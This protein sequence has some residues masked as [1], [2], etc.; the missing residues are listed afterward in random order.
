MP[1]FSPTTV[2]K[3]IL[4][5]GLLNVWLLRSRAATRFRGGDAPSL[6]S[7]FEAYGL[8]RW[9]FLAVGTLKI[10]SALAL[11]AGF[12]ISALVLPAALLVVALMCGALAMHLKVGD[13]AI[14]S[15]PALAMLAMSA[16]LCALELN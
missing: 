3:L 8:P 1:E 12:W 7:E 13:S 15:M 10:G 5:L 9:F 2:L 4:A 6:S 11:I 14:K 16:T